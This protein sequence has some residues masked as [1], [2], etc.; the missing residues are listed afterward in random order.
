MLSETPGKWNF[1]LFFI[2]LNVTFF[3]MHILGLMD[4]AAHLHLLA[5]TAS[6]ATSRSSV[7]PR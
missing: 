4:A 3:P 7:V 5:P 1:W 2:G 6:A